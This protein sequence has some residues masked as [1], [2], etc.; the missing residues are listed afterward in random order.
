LADTEAFLEALP[1]AVV[2]VGADGGVVYANPAAERLVGA[3]RDELAGRPL[4]DALP[5]R[6][7]AGNPWWACS[8]RLR[9]LPRVRPGT[10][11]TASGAS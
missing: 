5:L 4:D 3:G 10:G 9:R 6:D 1:D 2:V 11:A 8:E 7:G